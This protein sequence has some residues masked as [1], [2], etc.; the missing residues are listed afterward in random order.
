MPIRANQ[1][2]PPIILSLLAAQRVI[3]SG[4]VPSSVE[5][6]R[7]RLLCRKTRFRSVSG[8][9]LSVNRSRVTSEK[10][11]KSRR[12]ESPD[13]LRRGDALSSIF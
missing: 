11:E 4:K 9:R 1:V 12:P 8:L 2:W 6:A 7:G 13:R 5:T 3:L 10:V